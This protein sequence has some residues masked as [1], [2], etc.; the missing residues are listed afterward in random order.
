M[1]AAVPTPVPDG[2]P[3]R[4]ARRGVLCARGRFGLE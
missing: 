4:A 3:S 2:D 1:P